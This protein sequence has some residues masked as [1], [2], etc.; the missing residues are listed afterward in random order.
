[1]DYAMKDGVLKVNVR[2]AAAGYVLRRWN[3]DCTENHSL[4]GAEYHLWFKNC[5]ALYGVENL[6][7]APGYKQSN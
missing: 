5:Q 4:E 7:I 3:V 2:A 1:M 6:V